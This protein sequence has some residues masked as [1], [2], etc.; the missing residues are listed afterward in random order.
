MSDPGLATADVCADET[1][2]CITDVIDTLT[3]P[4]CVDRVHG[5][6]AC[7][8][9][10]SHIAGWFERIGLSPLKGS[11]MCGVRTPPWSLRGRNIYG[12]LP[13]SLG[14]DAKDALV[15]IAHHDH[16]ASRRRGSFPGADDNASGVAVLCATAMRLARSAKAFDRPIVFLST[17][18]EE[19]KWLGM[20]HAIG[21]LKSAGL[22][23]GAGL[24]IDQV[25]RC[26]KACFLG[27]L[28]TSP[29]WSEVTRNV[30]A[31]FETMSHVDGPCWAGE[32]RVLH[33]HGC[34]S[35]FLTS[36]RYA[37]YHTPLDVVDNLNLEAMDV[38]SSFAAKLCGEIAA[39]DGIISHHDVPL[40]PPIW[41]ERP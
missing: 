22:R 5:S 11:E 37:D 33:Q 4:D 28:A 3:G 40:S 21:Q 18:G 16:I 25:G 9:A 26:D 10:A 41:L 27:G 15:V 19:K 7:A 32:E 29:S 23:W 1:I 2:A 14:S 24:V 35:L 17:T 20:R 39:L 30:A 36:G 34:P 12:V 31:P 6:Q 13:N 8:R 38:L